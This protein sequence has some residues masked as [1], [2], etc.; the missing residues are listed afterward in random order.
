MQEA[1]FS[2]SDIRR[3]SKKLGLST[4]KLPPSPC[5]ASRIPYGTAIKRDILKK[6]EQAESDIK[7][8]RIDTIRVRYHD[9]VARI[10]VGKKEIKRFFNRNFCDK[11]I[12]CL[13]R[14]GFKYVALDL[15]GY[16]TGSLNEGIIR[17]PRSKTQNPK[18]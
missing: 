15:E 4:W 3:F 18:L 12:K 17:N 2:K 9:G 5:L 10:E 7:D 16:R 8:L 13:K 1:G 11:I 6:I 14:I